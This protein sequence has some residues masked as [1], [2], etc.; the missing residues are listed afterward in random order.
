MISNEFLKYIEQ[1]LEQW[2]DW[3]SRGNWYGLGYPVCSIEYRIMKEGILSKNT[4]Y[5]S[6]PDNKEA[7]EIEKLVNEMSEYNK[8]MALAIRCHYFSCGGLRT[9]AGKIKVS[10]MQYK[11]YVDMAHQWIVGRLSAKK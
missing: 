9:K 6:L 8:I 3:Y 11:S 2:A 7:E 4:G 1:R 10:H 5:R